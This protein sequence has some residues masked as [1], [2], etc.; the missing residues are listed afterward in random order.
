MTVDVRGTFRQLALAE[1][2]MD[3]AGVIRVRDSFPITPSFGVVWYREVDLGF[4]DVRSSVQDNPQADGTFD[5]TQYTGARAVSITGVVLNNAYGETPDLHDWPTDVYWNSASWFCSYLSAWASP[6]RRYRLYFTDDGGRSRYVDVRG[7][8]FTSPVTKTGQDY[9]EFQLAMVNPS[10][11]IYTFNEGALSTPD[12][13][14]SVPISI[15]DVELSGRTY[16]LTPP[17]TYPDEGGGA[18]QE[19]FYSGSVPNGFVIKLYTGGATLTGLRVTVTAPDGSEQSVGLDD[20]Y[21]VPAHT[22]VY[23][24]TQAR[25]VLMLE[26]NTTAYVAIDQYLAAPLQWPQ[27]KPGI[28]YSAS[29]LQAR[30]GYNGFS[31]SSVTSP[32]EDATLT[33]IYTAADL[34]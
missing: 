16:D 31:F 11:K 32:A 28:N 15:A 22:T 24:D 30:R 10:G 34:L 29:G 18:A 14:L 13:R 6:S 21:A 17:R 4:P 25:T 27:L 1:T 3:L 9:R 5:Q 2:Y 7:E 26:D 33:V 12:G 8:S 20:T 23:I 19:I